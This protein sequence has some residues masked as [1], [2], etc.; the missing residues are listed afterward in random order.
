MWKSKSITGFWLISMSPLILV[1]NRHR[2]KIVDTEPYRHG[3]FLILKNSS[4]NISLNRECF[5][6]VNEVRNSESAKIISE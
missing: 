3:D 4:Q 1:G 5:Q 6:D 2:S